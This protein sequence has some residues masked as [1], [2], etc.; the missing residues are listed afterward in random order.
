MIALSIINGGPGPV[1][2]SST[3]VDY[4]FGGISSVTPSIDD[5]P[6]VEVQ[7]KIRKVN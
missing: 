4:L 6:D 5:V 1:F 3:V 7:A 2:F